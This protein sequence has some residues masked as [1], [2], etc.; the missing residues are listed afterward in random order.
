MVEQG[1]SG[2]RRL[3][4]RQK[5]LDWAAETATLSFIVYFH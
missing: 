1:G 5:P 3:E 4:R 2:R